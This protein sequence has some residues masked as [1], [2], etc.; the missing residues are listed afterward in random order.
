MLEATAAGPKTN[1]WVIPI[2]AAVVLCCFCIGA[3]GL[4]LAFGGTLLYGPG[5]LN[6]L[7]PALNI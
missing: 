2:V 7:L 3:I 6:S 1:L 4:L 5:Q